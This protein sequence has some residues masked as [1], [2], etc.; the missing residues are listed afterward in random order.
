VTVVDLSDVE[1]PA[2]VDTLAVARTGE[3]GAHGLAYIP[4]TR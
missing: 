1:R 2:V 4:G 3:P